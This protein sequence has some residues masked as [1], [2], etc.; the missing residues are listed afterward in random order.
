MNIHEIQNPDVLKKMSIE[1][2]N[3]LAEQIRVFLISTLSKTG[4]H[5]GPNLGVVELTMALHYV[6]QSPEDKFIFDVG[7]QSYVHKMLTG[8]IAEMETIRQHGGISGFPKRSESEHDCFETGHSSTSISAALGMTLAQAGASH[9][10]IPIIGDGAL[11]GGMAFEALNHVGDINQPFIIILNDNEMSI[12]KNVGGLQNRLQHVRRNHL[13]TNLKSNVKNALDQIPIVGT[14]LSKLAYQSK[15]AVR[16]RL[17]LKGDQM[18]GDFNID[19][20]GPVDGHD[21]N[22]LISTFQIAKEMQHPVI[23]HVMTEKGRGYVHAE[24]DDSGAWHGISPFELKNGQRIKTKNDNERMW[25]SI[26]TETVEVLAQEDTDIVAITP[27]M[28]KGSK[29]SHFQYKF[30]DRLYDVG[31]AEQHAVTFAAGLA[32][33][34]KKPFLAIYSTFLQRGYD[35]VIHDVLLQDAPVVI[36]IDRCGFAAGDGA[37]HH[38]IYDVNFLQP[39]P[40]VTL[41]APYNSQEAQNLVY[42]SFYEY[43]GSVCIRYPRGYTEH[44]MQSSFETI[45]YG[46]WEKLQDGRDGYIFAY[47]TNIERAQNVIN[48]L[49]QEGHELGLINTRFIKPF[50]EEMLNEIAKS[51]SNLFMIEDVAEIGS[52]AQTLNQ[53]LVQ[54]KINNYIYSYAIPDCIFEHGKFEELMKDAQLDVDTLTLKI[55]EVLNE[56]SSS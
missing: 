55:K 38:G 28:I 47:G 41:V 44:Q 7:H 32:L 50:D 40:N 33:G 48:Q 52:F 43:T 10:I 19:Y 30:P 14:G 22:D 1:E 45:P 26:I 46:S 3:D 37:T 15:N 13:Y 5:V 27:A 51:G 11:T 12:S 35:Q 20:L 16:R 18:F 36:G 4:G 8:R 2:L 24:N 34:G 17:A 9:H 25:S 29:L 49:G 39:I 42:S 21:F 53:Y 54:H 31:I 23:I 6:F 56:K